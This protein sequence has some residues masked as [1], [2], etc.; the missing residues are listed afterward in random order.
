[1]H[2]NAKDLAAA[3]QK[4]DFAK[5]LQILQQSAYWPGIMSYLCDHPCQQKCKRCELEEPIQISKLERACVDFAYDAMPKTRYQP[6]R[7][8]KIAVVGSGLSGITVALY[9]VQKGYRVTIFEAADQIGGRLRKLPESK[10]PKA[11]LE[12]DLEL[13][14]AAGVEIITNVTV[15]EDIPLEKLTSEFDAVYLGIGEKGKGNL[16]IGEYDSTSLRTANPKVFVGGSLLGET[17]KNSAVLLV[18]SGQRAAISIDRMLQ[19]VSLTANRKTEGAYETKLHTSIEG[20]ARQPAVLP[21]KGATYTKEEAV[22]EAERCIQCR[23]LEC[24]RGCTYLKAFDKYPGDCIKSVVKNINIMTGWGVRRANNLINSCNICGLCK[25]MCP[26]DIDMG[27]VN[28]E[29]RRLM[30]EMNNLPAAFY[31]FPLRDMEFSNQAESAILKHQ[32]G[33]TTSKYLFFPGCQTFASMPETIKKVYRF[34]TENLEGGVGLM[35]QCCGV[36]ADWAGR[37]EL[38]QAVWDDIIQKWEQMGKPVVI[39]GCPGCYRTFKESMPQIELKMLSE[40][41]LTL[42]LPKPALQT[43]DKQFAFHDPCSTRHAR[44]VQ[45]STRELVRKLGVNFAELPY[46]RERTQCCGYGGLQYHMNPELTAEVV[47]ARTAQNPNPYLTSCTNCRDFFQTYGKETTHILEL[48]WGP[49]EAVT[50][51]GKEYSIMNFQARR[52]NRRR[53]KAEMLKEFWQEDNAENERGYR[54]VKLII[55]E[56]LQKKMDEQCILKDDL[57]QLIDFAEK[58]NQKML[59]RET[60]HFVAGKRFGI[61]T[62]WVEYT[63]ED[64]HYVVHNC[65]SHRMKVLSNSL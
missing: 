28:R 36:P 21:S 34:L 46:N 31:D 23:C 11:V 59:V 7:K 41:L 5:G 2:V 58:N 45:D 40:I 42:P 29:A 55:S 65:Y 12:R 54:K 60:G 52:D 32:P 38:A 44:V 22:R 37:Q 47:R 24:M 6:T 51:R 64:D 17:T 16:P 43:G 35:L 9:L 63:K 10:L 57:Q 56:A 26:M 48:I 25:E 20:Y 13:L 4:G 14:S 53:L 49:E 3:V 39:A 1:V 61:I 19:K 18:A 27:F 33:F 30:W 15:G 50:K 62:Y 8:H